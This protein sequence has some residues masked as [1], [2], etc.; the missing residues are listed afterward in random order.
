MKKLFFVGLSIF[1][2]FGL[3]GTFLWFSVNKQYEKQETYKKVFKNNETN[4]II[5]NAQNTDVDVKKGRYLEINYDGK[6]KVNAN[7]ENNLLHFSEQDKKLTFNAN[8]IPFRKVNNHLTITLP[9]KNYNAFNI[10]TNTGNIN[11][12]NVKSKNSNI[13]TGTG[14]ITFDQVDFQHV[15]AMADVGSI[16]IKNSKLYEFNGEL[17]TGNITVDNSVLK[18]NEMITSIGNIKIIDLKNE[19]DIKAS[20]EDGNILIDYKHKPQ[21]TLLQLHADSGS[22]KIENSAFHGEKVG[23]GKN[24]IESYTDNGDIKIK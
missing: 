18:N 4:Q 12:E 22:T 15:K 2:V 17:D 20:T 1:V 9:E 10:T 16:G 23:N 8:F 24:V 11:I 7:I 3:L 19:C 14:N 13:I 5:I 21:D 6:H